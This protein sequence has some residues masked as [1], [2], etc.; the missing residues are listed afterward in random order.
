MTIKFNDTIYLKKKL[1]PKIIEIEDLCL[2]KKENEIL[3]NEMKDF[4]FCSECY[5]A[6]LKLIYTEKRRYLSAV[7]TESHSSK[8][9]YYLEK[10]PIKLLKKL[11]EDQ[12]S[13]KK[14]QNQLQVLLNDFNISE[15]IPPQP[16]TITTSFP[17][18]KK[19]ITFYSS[20]GTT[21]Y[22]LP[23]QKIGRK[24]GDY[25]DDSK[26]KIYY[27]RVKIKKF[28]NETFFNIRLYNLTTHKL[29]ASLG[30]NK[31]Y[32]GKENLVWKY[33]LETLPQLID[34]ETYELGF[35]GVVKKQDGYNNF[36]IKHSNHLLIRRT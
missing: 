19:A 35:F 26:V 4:L 23:K 18:E 16:T 5:T 11:Y 2:I 10:I 8:C 21:K 3:F 28:E 1:T 22:H 17:K 27:G 33:L 15:N 25:F 7:S 13:P 36:L 29:I 12:E 34:N 20:S 14:I 6:K 9:S 30:I 24:N 31:T 32:Q